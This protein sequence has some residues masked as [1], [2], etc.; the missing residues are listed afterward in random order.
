MESNIEITSD[1]I[2]IDKNIEDQ[3]PACK[4]G[5]QPSDAHKCYICQK[6]VHA[7]DSCSAPV[8]EEGYGQKRICKNCQKRNVQNIIASREVEDW[9]GLA[10]TQE[11]QPRGRYLQ[12]KSIKNEFLLEK[13]IHK[14]PIIKNGGNIN[15]KAVSFD[16]K[17]Y[18]FTNTC[19]FDSILQLFIA[20]YLDKDSIKEFINT[21]SS[22]S[23]LKLICNGILWCT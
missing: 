15:I 7:L 23:L 12:G 16:K 6:N 8:G 9:H 2:D 11:T 20:A 17:N 5:D 10:I 1:R 21:E 19:A 13:N 14:I 3:C 22:N 18:S 4:N